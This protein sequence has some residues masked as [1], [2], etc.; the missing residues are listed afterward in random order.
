MRLT[1][2]KLEHASR[3]GEETL[4]AR[5]IVLRHGRN[6]ASYQIVNP[7]IEKWFSK[8]ED[9]VIGFV[10]RL[11]V[12]VVAG[13]PVCSSNVRRKVV[14]EF[15]LEADRMGKSVCYFGVEGHFGEEWA[16]RTAQ[17]WVC[18]GGQPCWRPREWY[19]TVMSHA[20]LRFQFNR[21]RNKGV[22]VEEWPTQ[23][24]EG[25]AQLQYVLEQWLATRGLPPLHFLVEPETLGFLGDRRTFVAVRE[26]KPV[27]FLNLCPIP[28]R[29]GWL[30]EQFPRLK[31]APNGTVELLM[32]EAVQ[33]LAAEGS[34]YVT[35][36]MVPLSKKV[37]AGP[38][39]T[40]FRALSWWA[41]AHGR[42]FYNF[43]G[44]ESFK[45]KFEPQWWEPLYVIVDGEAFRPH[46]LRAVCAA[47]V[48]GSV[49]AAAAKGLGRA[50][51]RTINRT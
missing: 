12:R 44:L 19:E 7:V 33:K 13:A 38:Q 41:R 21:A 25:N 20:T 43:E 4:R 46:H 17:T 35:M 1:A 49:W 47:F 23:K 3:I 37:T 42:R 22:V 6:A 50:V 45:S 9:A 32:H 30:T 29:Q 5:D 10:D 48:E 26:N 31:T 18:L 16:P 8:E 15:E 14:D 2:Q 27:A 24:A 28:E 39:P 34:E 36:G 51:V 40:W 11:G